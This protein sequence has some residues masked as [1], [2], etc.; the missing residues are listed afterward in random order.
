[1]SRLRQLTKDS[2][3]Y[4]V[5]GILAR[6]IGIFL[7]PVYTRIFTPADFGTIEMLL[8][9]SNLLGALMVMGMDSAQSF[10]FFEQ[11]EQGPAAQARAV[12][13]I[14]EWRLL[15]GAL[16]ILVSLALA[17]L[18]NAWLF[19]G[20]LEPAHFAF[21]FAWAFFFQL[22][23]QA[24]E[25]F[26]LMYKPW[27]YVA[28]TAAHGILTGTMIL[29]AVQLLRT[30][31]LGY[32]QGALTA[33]ALLCLPAWW[34][35]RNYVTRGSGRRH[36]WPRIIRFGWPLLPAALAYYV[37]SV[38]DR[39]FI[40]YFSGA[41]ELG[42]YAVAAKLG[43]AMVLAVE[44]FRKA[45]WPVAL[46]AMH[47]SDGPETFRLIS[48]LYVGGGTL[49]VLCVTVAAP[50]LM[51]W[52]A[53]PAYAQAY[54]IVGIMAW[55]AL[56]YGMYLLVSAGIW[57][58]E[59]TQLSAWLMAGGALVNG[60]LCY[61]LVPHWAGFGAALATATTYFL[62][63]AASY[64]VSER[65]WPVRL[66]VA[67]MGGIVAAGVAAHVLILWAQAHNGWL[68]APVLIVAAATI[69]YLT[70]A[71]NKRADLMKRFALRGGR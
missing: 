39:W 66:P 6:G 52:L 60:L 7:L 37:M 48:R 30:G 61:L 40:Q 71:G 67:A 33:T 14:L 26:R 57:K 31:T 25:L 32:F 10:F 29:V 50:F 44:T 13:A 51:A 55:Q 65:L 68:G 43:F 54:P 17:P 58:S 1:M 16:C 35:C 23:M 12:T 27:A 15:W 3:V 38:A 21:A 42:R 49:C 69:G 64:L 56:F 19:G 4:G 62:W 24:A 18:L 34:L 9:T 11:K 46:D 5:G 47:G 70:V 59:K 63:I 2:L 28:I 36:W 8:T 20:R 22:M 53:T 45:W 41:D